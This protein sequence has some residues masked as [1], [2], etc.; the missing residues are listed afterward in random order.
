MTIDD[1]TDGQK[2]V[3]FVVGL[4]E[5]LK[6]RGMV[7]GDVVAMSADGIE[8]YRQLR[9]SGFNPSQQ[10][11]KS[12]IVLL[13]DCSTDADDIYTLMKSL[14]DGRLDELIKGGDV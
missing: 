10:E 14:L 9:E 4:F 12:V 3:L 8:R 11:I 13:S 2:A 7:G 5:E 6:S 1:M